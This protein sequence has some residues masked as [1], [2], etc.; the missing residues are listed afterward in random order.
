MIKT[1]IVYDRV[2][3]WGGAERVLLALHEL[4]PDAPLYTAVYSKKRAPWAKVFPEVI[5]SFLQKIPFLNTRHELLGTFVPMAFESFNFDDYNLVISVTSEAAKGIITKPST[6][7]ICYC[8][9]P[10]RYLWSGY[11]Q[12]MND[13]PKTLRMIPFYQQLSKPVL[14]Y[15]RKWDK[16]ASKRPDHYIAISKAVKK[17]ISKYYERDSE[18][19]YPP[20][21]VEKFRGKLSDSKKDDGYYLIVSRL[22]PYKMVDLAVEAFN[23]LGKKLV[24][25]GTGSEESALKAIAKENIQFKGFV[26]EKKLV[27]LY[28][29]A[30]AFINPQE[31][32][33]GITAVEA[34]AAG[35]PVIAYAKG[36]ALDTVIDGKTG[37]YFKKQEVKSLI[38]AVKKLEKK[39][40]KNKQLTKNAQKFSRDI[41]INEFDELVKK[42]AK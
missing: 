26:K 36:G 9:T 12:Y 31:E 37:I 14:N 1:A 42:I 38:T 24:V 3:K 29:N 20:V 5:P 6:V 39:V 4:F 25:V 16:I 34:Q 35:V 32:D 23:E 33:F 27:S 13:P 41:F 15:V 2:N 30:K 18:I 21:N 19:I 22:V 17:R 28:K 40:F 10:T 7:H 8:L 11:D